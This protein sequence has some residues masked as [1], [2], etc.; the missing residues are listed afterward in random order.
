M[1]YRVARNG[2]IYGPYSLLEIER[3]ISTGNIVATDLAQPEGGE[4]WLTIESLFPTSPIPVARSL[5]GGLPTL[6][7]D[8]PNLPWWLMLLLSALTLGIFS[9]V[10]DVYESFWLRRIDRTSLSIFF[11][12]ASAVVF[13]MKLPGT[14]HTVLYNIGW[15]EGVPEGS[16]L[17][18]ML[19]TIAIAITARFLFRKELLRHFNGR[20]PIG[21]RLSWFLT[22]CCGGVYFQYHFN[23]INAVKHTLRVSVPG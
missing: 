18:F 10:W 3:H 17:L 5:P 4:E 12:I 7:P 21:L 16:S 6:Y 13:F 20:E 22:L 11:Y 1:T 19:F 2:Q 14:W 9:T 8:P 23:R 15:S